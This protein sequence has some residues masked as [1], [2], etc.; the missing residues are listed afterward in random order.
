MITIKKPDTDETLEV[1]KDA[2]VTAKTKDLIEFGYPNLTEKEVA[3]QLEAVL[4]DGELSI[5]GH[6]IKDDIVLNK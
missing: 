5:I 4:T 1:E 6:F 2:Y 3:D